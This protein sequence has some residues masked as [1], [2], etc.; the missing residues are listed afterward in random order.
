MRRKPAR[1]TYSGLRGTAQNMS[2]WQDVNHRRC[3][4]TFC[5]SFQLGVFLFPFAILT[6]SSRNA[7]PSVALIT[8]QAPKHAFSSVSVV[9]LQLRSCV[10]T[11]GSASYQHPHSP[12]IFLQF[13]L[14][15]C[16][17]TGEEIPG[18]F[19]ERRPFPHSL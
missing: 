12:V 7:S 3:S 18:L 10:I 2:A 8:L 9:G 15:G 5:E 4:G 19:Q 1:P 17:N 6:T 11:H 14:A 13:I 16:R